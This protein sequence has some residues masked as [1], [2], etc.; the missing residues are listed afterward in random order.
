MLQT[1]LRTRTV[2]WIHNH[3]EL[4]KLE[5][6][7]MRSVVLVLHQIRKSFHLHKPLLRT[8]F[9]LDVCP[10]NAH[11]AFGLTM[12]QKY[13]VEMRRLGASGHPIWYSTTLLLDQSKMLYVF[14]SFVK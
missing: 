11:V 5:E 12:W 9:T 13:V 14:T 7:P 1:L 8:I 6:K 4:Q 3:H 10:I 2:V